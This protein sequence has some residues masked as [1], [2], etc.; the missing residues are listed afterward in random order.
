MDSDLSGGPREPYVSSLGSDAVIVSLVA[1][2][3]ELTS[4]SFSP[5]SVFIK[6]HLS[7][8]KLHPGSLFIWPK[9]LGLSV[10]PRFLAESTSSIVQKNSRLSNDVSAYYGVHHGPDEEFPNLSEKDSVSFGWFRVD[11]DAH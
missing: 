2:C 7:V 4:S 6:R 1:L 8:Q 11:R 9:S 3:W 10:V 5:K